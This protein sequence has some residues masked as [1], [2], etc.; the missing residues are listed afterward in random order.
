MLLMG[1]DRKSHSVRTLDPRNNPRL[2]TILLPLP[3]YTGARGLEG[4]RPTGLDRSR[5]D[6][7]FRRYAGQIDVSDE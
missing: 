7:S 4:A 6:D 5:Q 3:A 1:P 2:L